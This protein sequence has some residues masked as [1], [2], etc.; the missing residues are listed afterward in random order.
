MIKVICKKIL[1]QNDLNRKI[2]IEKI[3][4]K[5]IKITIQTPMK[6]GPYS[7]HISYIPHKDN[8]DVAVL[9]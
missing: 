4:K 7:Q 5:Y 1:Y 3:N 6:G 9:F 2:I 8:E